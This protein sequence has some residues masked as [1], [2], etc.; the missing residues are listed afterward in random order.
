MDIAE[1]LNNKMRAN[2]MWR[3]LAEAVEDLINSTVG[4]ATD[5]S[6][7]AIGGPYRHLRG[8]EID[9]RS[10]QDIEA[11]GDIGGLTLPQMIENRDRAAN[12]RVVLPQDANGNAHIYMDL[13]GT[14]YVASEKRFHDRRFLI[15]QAKYLGFDFFSDDLTDADYAR[16]VSFVSQYWPLSGST[17]TLGK[18]LGFIRDIRIDL[19]QLWTV[20][21]GL[22]NYDVLERLDES[23]TPIWEGGKHYP[24]FHYDLYYDAFSGTRTEELKRLFYALAPIHLVLRRMIETI[25]AT[26]TAYAS[27]G[28]VVQGAEGMIW[29][30]QQSTKSYFI[31]ASF[32][33]N[34]INMPR[35]LVPP[36]LNPRGIAIAAM[37]NSGVWILERDP[38]I[39]NPSD[40]VLYMKEHGIYIAPN[41][42]PNERFDFPSFGIWDSGIWFMAEVPGTGCLVEIT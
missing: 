13:D 11:A 40:P 27:G 22:P 21:D 39:A 34:T 10:Y 1:L 36:N 20:D 31:K 2:P 35:N 19:V 7:N 16:V 4:A 42:D 29:R 33:A 32:D 24:T 14:T 23:M 41:T 3:A 12:V 28:P 17:G 9:P 38:E 30:P 15:N 6:M 37:G 8:D 18:F 25:R 26:A 5:Q